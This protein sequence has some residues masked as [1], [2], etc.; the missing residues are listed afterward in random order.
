MQEPTKVFIDW[1]TMH[2]A[3]VRLSNSLI[4]RKLYQNDF[5]VDVV[6]ALSR[7]GMPPAVCI[8]HMLHPMLS[9]TPLQVFALGISSYPGDKK[10]KLEIYQNID[11]EK[12]KGKNV[13]LVDDLVDSGDSLREAKALLI[14]NGAVNVITAVLHEKECTVFYPDFKAFTT[15]H[16]VWLVY[17]W[18]QKLVTGCCVAT[19]NDCSA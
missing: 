9:E 16:N 18:E 4:Q 15:K 7:G 5:R 19:S 10:S 14:A 6:V 2:K 8:S 11:P 3:C 1:E 12:I 17:P 13:L